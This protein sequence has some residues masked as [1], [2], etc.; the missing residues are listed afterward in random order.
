MHPSSLYVSMD[1]TQV[2]AWGMPAFIIS[3]GFQGNLGS[4]MDDAASDSANI[5]ETLLHAIV[6]LNFLKTYRTKSNLFN[7]KS[8]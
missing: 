6:L 4:V 8:H 1:T 2:H 5:S 7:I 3:P